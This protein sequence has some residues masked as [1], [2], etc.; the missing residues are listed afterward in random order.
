MEDDEVLT[1]L[2]RSTAR[3]QEAMKKA[4]EIFV[5]KLR[6]KLGLKSTT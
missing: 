2:A 3:Y 4:G 1:A 5:A 6:E